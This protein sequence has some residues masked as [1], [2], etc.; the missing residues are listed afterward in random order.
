MAT[1]LQGAVAENPGVPGFRAVV[2]LA[3]SESGRLDEARMLFEEAAAARFGDLP[4]DVTWL[5]VLCIYALL[6]S[7]LRDEAAVQ[8]LYGLLEPW[9]DQIAFPAFGVWGPVSL[10]LGPLAL[11]MGDHASAEHQLSEAVRVA[12]RMTAPHWEARARRHLA[13]LTPVSR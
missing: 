13:Q 8:A 10:Y 1:L 6:A 9:R 7:R 2:A 11:A 4:H 5:S 3:L 12:A